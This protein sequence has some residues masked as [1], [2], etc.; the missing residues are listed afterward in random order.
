MPDNNTIHDAPEGWE[1]YAAILRNV[2]PHA[3]DARRS[4]EMLAEISTGTSGGTR[5][6]RLM[7]WVGAGGLATAV[8]GVMLMVGIGPFEQLRVVDRDTTS[9]AVKAAKESKHRTARLKNRRLP[10]VSTGNFPA[11]VDTALP[12][13]PSNIESIHPVVPPLPQASTGGPRGGAQR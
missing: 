8:V 9:V 1:R 3:L 13:N 11:T 12:R 5:P 4:A 7:R 2:P 6:V 10:Q